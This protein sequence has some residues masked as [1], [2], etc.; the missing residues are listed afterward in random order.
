MLIMWYKWQFLRQIFD[1]IYSSII[2]RYMVALRD[3]MKVVWHQK[4]K[5]WLIQPSSPLMNW[6]WKLVDIPNGVFQLGEEFCFQWISACKRTQM[7]PIHSW[8]K[9]SIL[10]IGERFTYEI[11]SRTGY[12]ED[13]FIVSFKLFFVKSFYC[14]TL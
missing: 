4:Q 12:L 11:W 6:L 8:W 3:V 5:M 13:L 9:A 2:Y 1:L 14:K 10:L 7:L